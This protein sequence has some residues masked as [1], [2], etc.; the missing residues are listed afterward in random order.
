MT[1]A[2]EAVR[3]VLRNVVIHSPTTY[4][5]FGVRS[6]GLPA[7][8]RRSIG[9]EAV[10]AYLHT[11]LTSRLYADFYAQGWAEPPLKVAPGVGTSRELHLTRLSAAN[12]G[13]GSG[14]DGWTLRSSDGPRLVVER[15]GLS[16]WVTPDEMA[17]DEGGNLRLPLP[18][19]SVRMSPG[20]YMALG[21]AGLVGAGGAPIV[22]LYWNLVAEGAEVLLRRATTEL[23]RAGVPF[24]LKL[25]D[26]PDAYT[27]CDAAVLYV[28]R[29]D[30]P[31]VAAIVADIYPDVAGWL[32][33]RT[34]AF[35][36]VLAP[37]LGLAED[38]GAGASFG[39]H[40]CRLVADGIIRAF[41]RREPAD[42]RLSLVAERF[43]E[44][45]I[46]LD[47][48]F[49]NPGSTDGYDLPPVRRHLSVLAGASRRAGS[50]RC[51]P[52]RLLEAAERI[53]RR[54][55]DEAVW[56]GDLCNWISPTPTDLS[57]RSPAT[58][59]ALKA[60]LYNGTSGV[61]MFL[62]RLYAAA[63]D[64]AV[65]RTAMGAIRQALSRAH[66]LPEEGRSAL[67]TGRTGVALAAACAAP[68]LDEPDLVAP[69]RALLDPILDEAERGLEFD[70]ISGHA[71]TILGL[72]VVHD[73]VPDPKLAACAV[74]LGDRLLDLA[75]E[76]TAG[77]S[78]SSENAPA[79]HN[80][81]G[82][83][84][85]AAGG[86]TALAE[87]FRATGDERYRRGAEQAFRYE[88]HWFDADEGNWPDLRDDRTAR[89]PAR[90]GP[91]PY[92]TA[93]CHGAPGIALSRIR[94]YE[95]L[96]D[97]ALY[98]EA[99][100]ALQTTRDAVLG[101]MRSQLGNFS[102]CHGL[103]GN[104]DVL[105]QGWQAYGSDFAESLLAAHEVAR[106]GIEQYGDKGRPWPCLGSDECLSLM[107]GS[108]GIGYFLLRLRDPAIPSVLS[109]RPGAGGTGR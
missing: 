8:I 67:Y 57:V 69:G 40:R 54:F 93:W 16:L 15:H 36:K 11:F 14:S 104:A 37:G 89:K 4:S 17:E 97:E 43:A 13:T 66:A 71:G 46:S 5:W 55:V 72:L 20:F 87:L 47:T 45:G 62:A 2:Y 105:L 107:I 1:D 90:N 73:L 85:G 32:R 41:E 21:E 63:G 29:A 19:D 81:T 3:A 18:N 28:E 68:L 88:R 56:D 27:R 24:Q 75:E 23:N 12:A 42:N 83:S 99:A 35:T 108:A 22:R 70:V 34:P 44:D 78:W 61:A 25:L 94:A 106:F 51:D 49:L 26:S 48:P 50:G 39:Q 102:L 31:A 79:N 92:M 109:V 100:I 95:I 98:K 7:R 65:R 101:S 6:G 80:L 64:E 82:Y 76:S 30:Y 53:G 103:A 10:R 74:R 59:D 58:Y 9:P 38:P 86:G 96:G 52:Q 84:H 33:T 60:D 77:L 91:F